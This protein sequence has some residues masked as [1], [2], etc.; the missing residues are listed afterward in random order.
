MGNFQN[1]TDYGHAVEV[2]KP[3]SLTFPHCHTSLNFRRVV[4][5]IFMPARTVCHPSSLMNLPG[6]ALLL[7]LI[8]GHKSGLLNAIPQYSVCH[9]CAVKLPV[10]S[11]LSLQPLLPCCG[12]PGWDATHA[13]QSLLLQWGLITKKRAGRKWSEIGWGSAVG[14]LFTDHCLAAISTW[15]QY[16][17]ALLAA[18]NNCESAS[19]GLPFNRAEHLS[20]WL[21][22]WY[23]P[24]GWG[25][26][27]LF[28]PI[29][30]LHSL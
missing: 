9:P 7:L 5:R 23:L 11:S 24:L 25:E 12:G 22:S 28:P 21:L 26:F 30:F 13:L 6:T 1:C 27:S 17:C 3:F 14:I 16:S 18:E 2:F 19:K 15:W 29:Y 8:F 20:K 10:L 4:S